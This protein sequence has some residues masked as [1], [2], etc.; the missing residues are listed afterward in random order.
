[1]RVGTIVSHDMRPTP[2]ACAERTCDGPLVRGPQKVLPLALALA[3]IAI[4]PRAEG[5]E[6]KAAC[7]RTGS[8]TIIATA[9]VRVY[10]VRNGDTATMYGCRKSTGRRVKLDTRGGD[11][12]TVSD[13]YDRVQVADN[14]VSWVSTV[15]DQG[16]K[17]DCPPG[18]GTPQVRIAVAN[19]ATRRF[20]SVAAAPIGSAVVLSGQ[21]GVAWAQRGSVAG[22]V[23][24]HASERA[25]SN[26]VI[27][28]GAIEVAS[29][30]IEITIISWTRDGV[31]RF[32]R[33]R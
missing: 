7:A 11:G 16:C 23:E 8:R 14:Q 32:A 15:T 27:D 2:V 9:K 17:A 1:M 18:V 4:T 3:G 29:L 25:G 21:G 26:R 31:E 5:Q 28:S 24:I 6:R 20:R 19:V 12:Y 33:L 22:V 10:E 13:T 30:A